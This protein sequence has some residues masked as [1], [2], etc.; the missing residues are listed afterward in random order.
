LLESRWARA[1]GAAGVEEEQAVVGDLG[2]LQRPTPEVRLAAPRGRQPEEIVALLERIRAED[3][4][5]P[6]WRGIERLESDAVCVK[7][8]FHMPKEPRLERVG[9]V[10]VSCHLYESTP[11]RT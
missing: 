4:E 3:P 11:A 8:D 1:A 5:E 2:V 9:E 7:L 10:D 6:F